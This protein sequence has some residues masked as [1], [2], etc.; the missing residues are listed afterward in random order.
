MEKKIV[1]SSFFSLILFPL[2][3]EY[4]QAQKMSLELEQSPPSVAWSMEPLLC[5]PTYEKEGSLCR[6]Q[7][8]ITILLIAAYLVFPM[9]QTL[10]RDLCEVTDPILTKPYEASCTIILI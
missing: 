10:L 9:F 2:G 8:I 3:I 6:L 4:N 5:F 1:F 7:N